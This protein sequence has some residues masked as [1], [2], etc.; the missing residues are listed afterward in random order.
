[1]PAS[2]S[3]VNASSGPVAE[4]RQPGRRRGRRPTA[5]T[6]PFP[7]S[8]N[9]ADLQSVTGGRGD[10]GSIPNLKAEGHGRI[11]RR[12]RLR[13]DARSHGAPER[14][15][16]AW[17]GAAARSSTSRSRSRPIPIARTGV[18]PGRDNIV[19]T[20]DDGIVEVW[21]VPRTYPTFGQVQPLTIE[22]RAGRRR[23]QVTGRSR[24]RRSKRYSNRAGRCWRRTRSIAATCETTSA[25]PNPN[26]GALQLAELPQTLPGRAAER[27]L[28]AAVEDAGRVDVH[29]P[30]GRVLP[31]IVQVR[32]ALN[33][34]VN[35]I[36][37]G[38]AGRYD[39]VKLIDLRLAKTVQVRQALVRGDVRPVQRYQLERRPAARHDQ[40][41]RTT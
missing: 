30:A 16:Q 28:R 11:H 29:R 32:N 22:H 20:A 27:H 15:A 24:R 18:D 19:G 9:P 10:A 26:H 2:G 38:Q 12:R 37:E 21:S 17:I 3:G 5:G 36:V 34:L 33:Q 4:R 25:D 39:W 14:R 13:L 1:M 7:T 35:V 23:R 41:H 31:A 6:A 40:R 8:P